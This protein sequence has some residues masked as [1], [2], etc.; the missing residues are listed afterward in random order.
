MVVVVSD[1]AI[2]AKE[3]FV[4]VDLAA[5]LNRGD[6]ANRFAK[7]ARAAAFGVP[8]EPVEQTYFAEQRETATERA[9]ESTIKTL[10]EKARGEKGGSVKHHRPFGHETQDDCCLERLDFRAGHRE[11]PGVEG[12]CDER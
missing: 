8:F 3:A 5:A 7:P 10:D 1:L 6:W 2:E 4:H 12:Y 11:I 9:G